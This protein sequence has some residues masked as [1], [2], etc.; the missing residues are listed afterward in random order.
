MRRTA[1]LLLALVLF[2]APTLARGQDADVALGTDPRIA[3]ADLELTVFAGGLEFPMGLIALP[4]GSLLAGVS[5]PTGGSFFASEGGLL[6][7]TDRDG[8]GRADGGGRLLVAGI[9]G[10]IVALARAG[11][12]VFVTSAKAGEEAIYVFRRGDAWRDP[13]TLVGAIAFDFAGG[14]HQSYALAVRPT[15]GEEGSYDLVFNL[16]AHG[17]TETGTVVVASGLMTAEMQDA[18]LYLT[19]VTDDGDTVAF[20]EPL[21]LATG[22]RN[23]STIVF[24]RGSGD[25]IIGENGI[26][27]PANRIVSLGADE[28]D[29]IPAD[30]I[31]GEPEDFGF[32]AA[33]VVYDS[34]EAYGEGGIAPA[35]AFTPT[36]GSENEGIASLAQMPDAFPAA[37]RDG[38]AAGFH[39]QFEQAGAANEENPLLWV[40]PATGE[41]FELIANDNL[42]VG[43]LDTVLA[44]D[45][46][47]YVVDLC[48]AGAL[49]A[50]APCG[51]IYRL[52]A[53]S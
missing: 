37:L 52:T 14:E 40:D 25:L 53:A 6:R 9:P 4:D 36:D 5:A 41:R 2:A 13:L 48:T 35:V 3:A 16:G 28:L 32:P 7:L 33:Y 21:L 1:A 18:S 38:Y 31:G 20:S 34:G 49:S 46:A 19:T 45:D 10:P 39:G 44:T 42:N 11:E 43:H 8:D 50:G 12:L 47:L 17:N 22:L 51:A 30:A 24:A 26:D 23:A 15:P 29:V 27:N